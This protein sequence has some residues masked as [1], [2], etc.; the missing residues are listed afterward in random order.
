MPGQA[1][2][3]DVDLANVANYL[4]RDLNGT[5]ELVFSADDFVRARATKPTHKELREL[6][7]RLLK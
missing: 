7:E 6:R 3:S 4:A 2:L 1:G 5:A